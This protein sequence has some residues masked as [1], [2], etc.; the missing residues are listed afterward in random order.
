MKLS[1]GQ[2]KKYQVLADSSSLTKPNKIN[3]SPSGMKSWTG[4]GL[5]LGRTS[6]TQGIGKATLTYKHERSN[7]AGGIRNCKFNHRNLLL[8]ISN[9]WRN[10]N[11]I[12]V[13]QSKWECC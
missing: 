2:G 3:V 5:V 7:N 1:S 6:D 11:Y 10:S 9:C 13:F 4:S 12:S 8:E